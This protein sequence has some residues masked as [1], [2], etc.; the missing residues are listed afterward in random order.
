MVN[1]RVKVL[2]SRKEEQLVEVYSLLPCTRFDLVGVPAITI[3][4]VEDYYGV[5]QVFSNLN[6]YDHLVFTSQ[7]AVTNTMMHLGR[8]GLSPLA[9]QHLTTYCVGPMVSEQL[10]KFNLTNQLMPR[11]YTIA[12]L[13][14][15]FPLAK[16]NKSSV[17]FPV[18]KSTL[19]IL[20]KNLTRKGYHVV[21]PIVYK[22]EYNKRLAITIGEIEQQGPIDCIAFTS[23]ASVAAFA[24]ALKDYN[25]PSVDYRAVMCAIGPRTHKACTDLGWT[26]QIVPREYTVQNM[27]RAIARYFQINPKLHG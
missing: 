21:T 27:A 25:K 15:L 5:D 20:E 19:G 10:K 11:E 1:S 9:L 3:E 23:P 13:T 12:A 18:G 4:Q 14:E 16:R 26:V 8:L 7:Y 6:S 17:L 22:A 24:N 2:F